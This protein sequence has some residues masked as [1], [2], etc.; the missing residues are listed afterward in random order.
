[1]LSPNIFGNYEYGIIVHKQVNKM[2]IPKVLRTYLHFFQTRYLK[3][4]THI[5]LF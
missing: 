2:T 4:K 5:F 3:V 1:M